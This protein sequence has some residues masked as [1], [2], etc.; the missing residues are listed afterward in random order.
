MYQQ[1]HDAITGWNVNTRSLIQ[2]YH[3]GLGSSLKLYIVMKAIDI[4]HEI[5]SW[6]LKV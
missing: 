6:K 4:L 2:P 5:L 3:V 1:N